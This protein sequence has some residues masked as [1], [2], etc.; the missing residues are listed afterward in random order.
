M[1]QKTAHVPLC[2]N[3]FANRDEFPPYPLNIILLYCANEMLENRLFYAWA[4]GNPFFLLPGW[5]VAIV[6]APALPAIILYKPF[7]KLCS[8][9]R[10]FRIVIKIVLFI[11]VVFKVEHFAGIVFLVEDR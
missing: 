2:C 5:K 9:F 1:A 8:F 11:G 3:V 10:P 6:D 7:E 4:S